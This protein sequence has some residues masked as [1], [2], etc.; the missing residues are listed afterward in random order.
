MCWPISGMQQDAGTQDA[1]V[2]EFGF[3]AL[4]GPWHAGALNPHG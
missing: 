1:D 2:T 3:L 4:M